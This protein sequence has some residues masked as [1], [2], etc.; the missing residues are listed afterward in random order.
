MKKLLRLILSILTIV[1]VALVVYLFF[2]NALFDNS[3]TYLTAKDLAVG[4]V[5]SET[6]V[7]GQTTTLKLN[8]SNLVFVA[9]FLPLVAAILS[10]FMILFR[11]KLT[12]ILFSAISFVAVA[13][14]FVLL[15]N[16]GQITSYELSLTGL[17]NTSTTSNLLSYSFTK[18]S[19]VAILS[20][21]LGSCFTFANF[22][23][24][25]A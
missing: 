2:Q 15:I 22:C 24:S 16:L 17:I 8:Q 4:K 11:G 23:L 3:D 20:L 7:L 10:L 14:A 6:T 5:I 13:C 21:L 9:Y 25:L 1:C 18:E 19:I 12:G